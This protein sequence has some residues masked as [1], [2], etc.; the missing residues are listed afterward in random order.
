MEM[1]KLS[2]ALL[3]PFQATLDGKSVSGFSVNKARALLAYLAVDAARAH[4][5]EALATLLWPER[6]DEVALANL[7]YVL[8]NLRRALG[9]PETTA[10][11]L[12]VARDT[13]QF[14]R[15]SDHWLDV[16]AFRDL[17]SLDE[18]G[19]S[20]VERLEQAIALYRGDF[21]AGFALDDSSAFEEWLTL[22]RDEFAGQAFGAFQRLAEAYES[23]GDHARAEACVRRQL[24]LE[25]WREEAHRELMRLL[26]LSGRRSA[27]L[28]QYEACRRTLKDELDVEP[29]QETTTLMALIRDGTLAAAA[30]A[31]A[32]PD[33]HRS[34]RPPAPEVGLAFVAR[35]R[36]LA[37]LDTHLEAALAGH[38]RVAF[39][40][41]EAG[42][43]KTTLL[44]E[45]LRRAME[46]HGDLV[47]ALGSCNAQTGLGDPYLPFRETLQ[48]LTCDVEAK[49]ARESISSEHARRL[50]ALLPAV[51][52]AL[53][54]SGPNLVDLLVPGQALLARAQ[55]L[56]PA[57]GGASLG[58]LEKLLQRR[59]PRPRAGLQ[60]ADLFEQVTRVVQC[61]ARRQTLVLVLDDLQWADRGSTSLLF[62][63]GRRLAGGRILVLGAY[64]P[65]DGAP[66]LAG[67]GH[68]FESVINELR[69][70]FGNI[71]LDLSQAEGRRFVAELL[72]SEP[73]RLGEGF[74]ENL[75]RRT[76]GH[77]LFTVELLRGLQE[78][79]E[80]LKDE[81]GRWVEGP[82][83]DW[84]RLPARVEAT[85]A[86]RLAHLPNDLQRLLAVASVA[87]EEFTA[88]TVAR[89]QDVEELRV[90]HALSGSLSQEHRLVVAR[91]VRRVDGQ[92]LSVYRFRHSL[93]QQYL[94]GRLDQVERSQL[95][96]AVG[97][98]LEALH[99]A[100]SG[101]I[102][103]ELARHFEAAGLAIKAV[104]YSLQAGNRAMEMLAHQEAVRHFRRGLALLSGVPDSPPRDGQELDL[105]LAL[106]S[107]LLTTEGMG[108]RGQ[109]LAYTRAY[110]LSRR[111]GERGQLWPALHAL[112]SSS[113][114]RG[115]YQKALELGEQLLDL[116]ERS[117]EPAVVA[118]AHFTL[119]ATLFSSAISLVRS[120][121]HLEQAI[122]CYEGVRD[123]EARR[124][125]TSL[126][127]FDVG[128]NARAWLAT[129]LWIL[130]YPDQAL[131]RSQEALASAQQLNHFLSLVLAL[132]AACHAR[133][134]RSEH[135]ALWES[136]LTLE[137]LISGKHL[138][139]GDV[140]VDVFSGWLL[141]DEG[142]VERGLARLRQGTTAWQ[143]AGTV[144]GA[145]AQLML[146]TEACL[147][148]GQMEEGLEVVTRTLALVERTGAR[149]DEAELRR[150]NGDLL[151]IRG[152]PLDKAEAEA[153]FRKAIEIARAGKQKTWELRAA[154]SLARLWQ[155]QGKREQAHALL[156]GVYDWFTEGFDLPDLQE[157]RTALAELST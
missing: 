123:P 115:E 143:K 144:F 39:V 27:A 68:P 36:E 70:E 25:P 89:A 74:R 86:E 138:L 76:E 103:V 126:N 102:A 29:S 28:A 101:E 99:G 2:L 113:T 147:R 96:E 23:R 17:L 137:R 145:P 81:S 153:C 41:G 97:L 50:W 155:G 79:G 24:A 32:R 110:E 94:Y 152:E 116:A 40:V 51:L 33:A 63:L 73:N 149:S 34:T 117:A 122:L 135:Q 37:W 157:A 83:L 93:F 141:V 107:A 85:I 6:P 108:S 59:P 119:G 60:Q 66:D 87:G 118:L 55:A 49:R 133:Q 42:S 30:R 18:A 148:A 54:E 114:S 151:L 21:L 44:A 84:E 140:W 72:D 57:G 139:V 62:H 105:Q 11:L 20:S 35:E 7:R 111:L 91:S 130:G 67:E 121:E 65:H 64:R 16:R 31:F 104:R 43:G 14:N 71:L 98:A 13:L 15:A 46:K 8:T 5:R 134:H 92:R 112:A 12:L 150:L 80:L 19:E 61:L 9:D 1:P 69:R 77:A 75:Y 146:L 95:H 47:V 90:I 22:R 127:L 120:R 132:Y 82:H 52:Q 136:V 3:G 26:A 109:I 4:S 45:F 78:R 100:A 154:T 88:E 129:V 48:M 38:G 125:L 58:R 124:F 53:V 106:G 142:Q 56:G 10:P 128:V 156:A 131:R